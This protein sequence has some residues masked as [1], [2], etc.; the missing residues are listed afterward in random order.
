MGASNIL[1]Q[2]IKKAKLQG[3]KLPSPFVEE[4]LEVKV[5]SSPFMEAGL[6][7]RVSPL[8]HWSIGKDEACLHSKREN[9]DFLPSFK[10]CDKINLQFPMSLDQKI[11]RQHRYQ[12]VLHPAGLFQCCFFF[13]LLVVSLSIDHLEEQKTINVA[14]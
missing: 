4:G 5:A 11:Q 7:V 10:S 3:I 8:S 1:T 14:L 13:G 9:D 12:L 6:G 2:K